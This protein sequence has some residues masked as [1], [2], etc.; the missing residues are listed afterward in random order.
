MGKQVCGIKAKF[1][2]GDWESG[3][4]TQCG[5][6]VEQKPEGFELS[7][8][9]YL[10][11]LQEIN[12]CAIRKKC[13]SAPTTDKEKSQLRALLGGVRWHRTWQQK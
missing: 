7:Q 1:K 10:E 12:I 3:R 9:H 5:V 8:P 6:V 4:F 2:W 11:N 13:R